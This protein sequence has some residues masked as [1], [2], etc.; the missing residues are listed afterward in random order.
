M[1]DQSST[2]GPSSGHTNDHPQF[3]STRPRP[4]QGGYPYFHNGDVL[5]VSPTG[6]QWK[7]HSLILAKAAPGF[8]SIFNTFDPAH[9]SKKQREEGRMLKWKLEMVNEAEAV[10]TDPHGLKY[11]AF[12]PMVSAHIHFIQS[13][14]LCTT[15]ISR[16]GFNFHGASNLFDILLFRNIRKSM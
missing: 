8:E 2:A 6:K 10:G 12:R 11:K 1:A 15:L 14:A 7:L 13:H 4:G 5:I 9:I 16:F 3:Q